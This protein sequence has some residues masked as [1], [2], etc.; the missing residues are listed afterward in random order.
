MVE[1]AMAVTGRSTI[2]SRPSRMAMPQSVLR[3]RSGWT[4]CCSR[5]AN[6]F[7]EEDGTCVGARRCQAGGDKVSAAAV[8]ETLAVCE[9]SPPYG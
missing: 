1:A 7:C 9:T 6:M 4:L 3:K 2:R 5:S 8:C